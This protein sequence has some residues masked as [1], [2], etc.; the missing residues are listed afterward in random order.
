MSVQTALLWSRSRIIFFTRIRVKMVRFRNSCDLFRS[1]GGGLE[2][3]LGE[4]GTSILSG[5]QFGFV[6][7]ILAHIIYEWFSDV[8]PGQSGQDLL[9]N[10][11]THI[12]ILGDATNTVYIHWY[13]IFFKQLKVG[14]KQKF[15]FSY[16]HEN[17]FSLF[18]KKAYKKLRKITKIFAK[19][20]AKTKMYEKLDAGNGKY[21]EIS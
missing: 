3:D 14:L 20:F 11:L 12:F 9:T 16:F 15:S 18:A 1:A 19:M 13:L 4:L 5:V 10:H 6:K 2:R 21:C 8:G 17:L 7:K